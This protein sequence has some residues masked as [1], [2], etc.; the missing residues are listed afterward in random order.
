MK[1]FGGQYAVPL[2]IVLLLVGLIALLGMV[3]MAIS[4]GDRAVVYFAEVID[5][6]NVRSAAVELRNAVVTAE[7]SQRGFTLTGNEVYLAPYGTSRAQAQRQISALAKLLAAAKDAAVPLQRLS[8]IIDAKFDEMDQVIALTRERKDAEALAIIATNRGKALS[9]EANVFLTGMIIA[10]DDRLSQA[11]EQHTSNAVGLRL[12]SII[13]GVIII[14]VV[15]GAVGSIF[16]HTRQLAKARDEVAAFNTGLEE[17]VRERTAKLVGLNA[18]V[19]RFAYVVTH[20]LRAPL[21]NIMGFTSELDNSAKNLRL[22]VDHTDA[23]GSSTNSIVVNART[24]VM[25]D[26]PEAISFIRSSTKKMDG[27]INAIL[28]LSR[29][30][31][32]VLRAETLT[33]GDVIDASAETIQHQLAEADGTIATNVNVPALS[34]DR[35]SLES[36]FG[37]LFD[38]AVKYRSRDRALRIAVR[39]YQRPSDRIIVEVADNGRGIAEQDQPRVFELFRRAGAREEPGEGI[40]LARVRA[41]VRNLGGEITLTSTLD[42]GTTFRIN[43]PRV[44]R[45]EEGA[46]T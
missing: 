9:D 10:A 42:V 5:A 30:G 38:N 16:G 43:L 15:G 27:L 6:R 13:A 23:L 33:L 2:T 12:L 28:K 36:V 31:R 40:G 34:Q 35:S 22:L 14:V 44:L 1:R 32:R 39:A 20:D 24:A 4:L 25:E 17:R 46:E 26:I 7:S 18:E 19:Q 21:V 3:G 45:S 8:S 11:A 37:N 29:E 41:V